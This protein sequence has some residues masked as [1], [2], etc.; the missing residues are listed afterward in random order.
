MVYF[1][2]LRNYTFVVV[3]SQSH[4]WCF[5]TPWT[6]VCQASRSFTI[7]QS[8]LKNYS[9]NHLFSSDF[10]SFFLSAFFSVLWQNPPCHIYPSCLLG[11]F[12]FVTV[13]LSSLFFMVWILWRLLVPYFIAQFSSVVQARLPCP[14]LTPGVYENLCPLS[15]WCHPTISSSVIPFSSCLQSFPASESFL[16][17]QFFTSGDQSIGVSAS[18]SVLPMNI[19]DWFPLA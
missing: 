15:L 10:T 2:K 13:S 1:L 19:P 4:V 11:L 14:S 17:S 7:S 3:Q 12:W 16:V 6:S 9:L 8:L 5:V 18:A